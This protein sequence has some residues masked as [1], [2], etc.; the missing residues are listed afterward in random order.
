MNELINKSEA[1]KKAVKWISDQSRQNNIA[2]SSRLLEE[3]V[4]RFDLS[5]RDAEFIFQFYKIF[6]S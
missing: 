1:V 5:P 2:I 6:K 3:A 4:F